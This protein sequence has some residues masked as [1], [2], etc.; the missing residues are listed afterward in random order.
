[1][2]WIVGPAMHADILTHEDEPYFDLTMNTQRGVFK[3][4]ASVV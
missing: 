1:M 2:K 4:G 3:S